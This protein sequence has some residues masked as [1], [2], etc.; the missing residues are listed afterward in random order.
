MANLRDELIRLASRAPELRAQLLPLILEAS[1]PFRQAV[2]KLASTDANL[3]RD[4]VPLLLRTA[5]EGEEE[6]SGSGKASGKFIQFMEEEGDA[7]VLNPDTGNTVKIKSLRGPKGKK[8]VQELFQKWLEEQKEDKPVKEK[9][10]KD[11]EKPKDE[12]PKGPEEKSE[13]KESPKDE[14]KEESKFPTPE[15]KK[16][17]YKKLDTKA[18]V[19]LGPKPKGGKRP[20]GPD[21]VAFIKGVTTKLTEDSVADLIGAPVL[22]GSGGAYSMVLSGDEHG[23]RVT[24]TGPHITTMTRVLGS[25]DDGPFIYNDTLKLDPNAPKGLGTKIFATQV[26]QARAAGVKKIKCNA[27]RDPSR[28]DWVGYKVWPKLGYDGEI[29]FDKPVDPELSTDVAPPFPKDLEDRVK[30][31]GFKEPYRVSHLLQV[32]GGAEWWDE[33]GVSFNAEFDLGDD[34]LSMKVLGSYLDAKAKKE[35]MDP[36]EW[37]MKSAASKKKDESDEKKKGKDDHEDIE[38]DEH[39]AKVLDGIWKRLRKS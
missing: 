3:R 17:R 30:K 16:D 39:D 14:G 10:P 27:F 33:N 22:T 24:M 28:P 1:S 32:E 31:A 13:P 4:L 8:V 35:D 29:P 38:L 6:S 34:S 20:P 5:D 9:K 11:E 12:K 18:Y 26:A 19:V 7:K 2:V 37:M 23:I 36:A 21:G 15:L 25:D